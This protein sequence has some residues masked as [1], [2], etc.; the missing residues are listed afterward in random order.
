MVEG[1]EKPEPKPKWPV[2]RYWLIGAGVLVLILFIVV[3]SLGQDRGNRALSLTGFL[4]SW[5]VMIVLLVAFL[6]TKF[7]AEI[8]EFIHDHDL[9]LETKRA[10]LRMKLNRQEPGLE[11]QKE[12]IPALTEAPTEA[13]PQTE[14]S[15]TFTKDDMNAVL[16]S[17]VRWYE[18]AET[19]FYR[20]LDIFLVPL[21][22]GV[23]QW[24]VGRDGPT[25]RQQFEATWMYLVPDPEQRE[26]MLEVLLGNG[27]IQDHGGLIS[28]TEGGVKYFHHLAAMGALPMAPGAP[29]VGPSRPDV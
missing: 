9:D 16:T 20:Y 28:A 7:H 10:T 24:F 25:T 12:D 19:W 3:L 6:A 23:L 29:H 18:Q 5:P 14:D 4:L 1:D 2:S 27:L 17:A 21:T 8:A 11:L 22:K 26:T 13:P 15:T